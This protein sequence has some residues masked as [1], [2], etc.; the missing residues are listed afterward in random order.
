MG[1]LVCLPAPTL[2]FE[3]LTQLVGA[4]LEATLLFRAGQLVGCGAEATAGIVAWIPASARLFSA[5]G[6]LFGRKLR[7]WLA[8]DRPNTPG[9]FRSLGVSGY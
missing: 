9:P 8:G 2:I 7:Q 5:F 3:Q 4:A 6:D 1:G